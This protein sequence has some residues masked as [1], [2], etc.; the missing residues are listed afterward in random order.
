MGRFMPRIELIDSLKGYAIILVLIGHVIVLSNPSGFA[1]SW[2]FIFIYA[3]HMPLLLFLSGYLVGQKPVGP[4]KDFIGKKCKG[5]LYPYIVWLF[6]SIFIVNNF[7]LNN[8]V[9]DYLTNH[10][11]FFDNI[12]FLPVLFISFL[13]LLLFIGIENFLNAY[14]LRRYTGICFL[15]IYLVSWRI[16]LPIQ[17]LVLIRWF[18]PFVL[19]G[20]LAARYRDQIIEKEYLFPLSS[21]IFILLLPS[22]SQYVLIFGN[23]GTTN[24]I[25]DFVLAMTGIIMAFGLLWSLR[26][27]FVSKLLNLCGFFSLE[28]YLVSNFIALLLIQIFRIHF[29]IDQ[30]L[31]AYISGTIV[32]LLISIF[33]AMI[34]SYN[35]YVSLLLFGRWSWKSFNDGFK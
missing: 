6:I 7:I 23:V 33:L 3:F 16:D 29:W 5:L 12:W 14:K 31:T 22:W 8:V 21:V 20:Y 19:I 11:V 18:S 26:K 13:L 1:N 34:L 30:G 35:K 17:G 15:M 32:F 25:I 2:L 28:I 4:F 27:T 24:L 9:W 10:L